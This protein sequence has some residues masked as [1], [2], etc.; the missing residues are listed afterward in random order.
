MPGPEN[1]PF[2][3]AVEPL[4]IKHGTLVVIAQQANRAIRNHRIKTFAG[5]RTVTDDVTQAE[6]VLDAL[7]GDMRQNCLECFEVTV[8]VTNYC[9][10]HR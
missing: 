10:L 4:G 8:D 3:S 2:G 6:H 9:A 1:G 5:I 7:V